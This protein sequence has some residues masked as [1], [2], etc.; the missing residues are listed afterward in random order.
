MDGIQNGLLIKFTYFKILLNCYISVACSHRRGANLSLTFQNFNKKC[1]LNS[2]WLLEFR[3]R[4]CTITPLFF[5]I[6]NAN[7]YIFDNH[8]GV[9][10]PNL[11]HSAHPL[12]NFQTYLFD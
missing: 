2:Y 1:I 9:S 8:L 10:V 4:D 11:S 7:V 5:M 12:A 6:E 3:I